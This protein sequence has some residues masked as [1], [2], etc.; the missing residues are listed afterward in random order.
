MKYVEISER[1]GEVTVSYDRYFEYLRSERQQFPSELYLYASN[2]EHYSLDGKS[3][4]HDAWLA[5]AQF[6]YR[7]KDLILEF[8]GSRHDRKLIFQ[9]VGVRVYAFDLSVQF[10][11]GD[12]DVLA[13]EFRI[14]RGLITHEIAFHNG[15]FISVTAEKVIPTTDLLA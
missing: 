11:D 3:S 13:H 4:L 2:L 9:Y 10:R 5:G 1:P 7:A 14:D 15:K 8:L 12:G 6:A